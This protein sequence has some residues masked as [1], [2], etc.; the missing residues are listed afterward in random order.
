MLDDVWANVAGLRETSRYRLRGLRR[1]VVNLPANRSASSLVIAAH[2]GEGDALSQLND[3]V[4]YVTRLREILEPARVR[5]DEIRSENVPTDDL[6]QRMD[7][8]VDIATHRLPALPLNEAIR[9]ARAADALAGNR[10]PL[11]AA[12]VADHVVRA[13][14]FTLKG[15]FLAALVRYWRPSA[16]L[17]LGT[18]L[19]LSALFLLAE[20]AALGDA[21]LD[22]IEFAPIPFGLASELLA[23]EHGSRSTCH[24][25]A[26]AEILPGL[27]G[28]R[29]FD[30]VFHDAAHSGDDYVN[31][32]ALIEP[33]MPPGSVFVLDDIR[34]EPTARGGS[35]RTYEGWLQIVRHHR[36][37]RAFEI[38]R[39][40][41]LLLLD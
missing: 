31:D 18:A 39:S 29:S 7:F 27:A 26:T 14:S 19:G 2:L 4:A 8:F 36:V 15:R 22:T 6:S 28:Q 25:G 12:D 23:K 10:Q 35:A 16:A 13:S 17:E 38:D 33:L 1:M 40:Y 3:P 34:W 11:Y 24:L 41:G 37:R 30:M 21:T 5:I 32:F 20:L 9:I